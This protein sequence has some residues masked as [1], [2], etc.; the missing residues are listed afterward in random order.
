VTTGHVCAAL[1][2]AWLAG[3]AASSGSNNAGDDDD[4]AA[5]DD[6]DVDGDTD[7]DADA[8]TDADT[9]TDTGTLPEIELSYIWVTNHIEGTVS[10]IDTQTAVEVARYRTCPYDLCGP[11]RTSV[12]LHGDVVVTNMW[13]FSGNP[14]GAVKFA[15]DIEDGCVDQNDNDEIETSTGP[16]DVLPWDEEECRL[17][18]T[19]L[20]GTPTPAEQAYPGAQATAWD[21]QEDMFTGQGGQVY[22][23][24]CT[25]EEAAIVYRID[26]DTGEILGQTGDEMLICPGGGAMGGGGTLWITDFL[27]GQ[28]DLIGIDTTSYAFELVDVPHSSGIAIDGD[29]RV[30]TVGGS[31]IARYDPAT[32]DLVTATVPATVNFLH[33]VAAGV[34]ASDG[35]VWVTDGPPGG[36]VHKI[37]AE[38][39]LVEE[40]YTLTDAM[41]LLY[42][43]SIDF[44]GNVWAVSRAEDLAYKLDP[45]TEEVISVPVG[46]GPEPYSDMTGVQYREAVVVE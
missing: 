27:L 13:A 2:A 25:D 38:T 7:S 6:T 23:G 12:N 21:G 41:T 28:T 40:S 30:F 22:V 10:K 20:T 1:M 3:C 16:Y 46:V 35:Y 4:T 19:E 44:E 37:D 14:S 17:W 18:Y 39:L 33:C 9:D 5:D 32:L 43:I 31:Y 26:G 29:G 8:D 15:A 11:S 24:L 42:G 36:V 45:L 34:E